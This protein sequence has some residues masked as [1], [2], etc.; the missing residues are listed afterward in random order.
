LEDYRIKPLNREYILTKMTASIKQAEENPNI[1][2][3]DAYNLGDKVNCRIKNMT[4]NG[5][6]YFCLT[7]GL[8]VLIRCEAPR[9]GNYGIDDEVLVKIT[10]K[11]DK[12][13]WLNGY[14]IPDE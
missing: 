12:N 3:F 10:E 2:Y 13:H 11:Q 5:L 9:I 4:A 1:R 7:E 8:G 6:T 14:I